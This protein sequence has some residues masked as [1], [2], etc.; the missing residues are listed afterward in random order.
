MPAHSPRSGR[1][2]RKRVLLLIAAC[3]PH[4]GPVGAAPPATVTDVSPSVPPG[5]ASLAEGVP[6]ELTVLDDAGLA[7][8]LA[9]P[10]SEAMVVNFWATWCG[11]CVR[12]MSVFREVAA[13]HPEVRF[14]LVNVERA[15]SG[16]VDRFLAAEG[17]GLPAFA[18]DT[19]DASSLLA[20]AVPAWPDI[21]PVTLVLDPGG[22]VRARFDGELDAP[23]LRAA[24]AP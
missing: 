18:L 6:T 22:A 20:R 15:G 16:A 13:E 7:S 3:V 10:G 5:R 21:I 19:D 24:L 9:N 2:V 23:A 12:E 14:A 17:G 4:P 8:L 11:P 1:E